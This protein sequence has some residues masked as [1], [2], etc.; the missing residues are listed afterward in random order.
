[1]PAR[2]ASVLDAGD[3][4]EIHHQPIVDLAT[5]SVVGYEALSRFPLVPVRTPDLWFAEAFRVGMGV[6]LEL[7]AV[8]AALDT[9]RFVPPD[10]YLS[11]NVSPVTLCDSHVLDLLARC[12]QGGRVVFEVTE[13]AAVDDHA[14]LSVCVE[15]L[16]ASGARLA[17]D[18]AGSGYA[19]FQHIV[20]LGAE[21]IKIDRAFVESLATGT[22]MA[23]MVK[24]L[25]T[26]ADAEDVI[27]VAEG[28]ETLAQNTLLQSLGVRAAQGYYFGHPKR[29]ELRLPAHPIAA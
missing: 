18:D 6:E 17:I 14:A 27:L 3:C 4:L 21:I 24:A 26:F 28:V 8:A 5:G 16:R 2:S 25:A 29:A 22:P 9:L 10:S 20:L 7:G 1:M 13:H 12:G 15:G 23:S 11:M 19:S